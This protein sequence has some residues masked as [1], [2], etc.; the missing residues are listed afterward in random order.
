M[1]WFEPRSL[2]WSID[3]LTNSATPLLSSILSVIEYT[4]DYKNPFLH[5]FSKQ[6]FCG[7]GKG[8]RHNVKKA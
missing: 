2:G 1:S 8:M 7:K 3:I 5:K 6:D 4:Q